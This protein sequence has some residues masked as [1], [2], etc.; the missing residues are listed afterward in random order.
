M[1]VPAFAKYSQDRTGGG[2][3]Y[4]AAKHTELH[5]EP[6]SGEG[7]WVF[8][9]L[10]WGD[11]LSLIIKGWIG[12]YEGCGVTAVRYAREHGYDTVELLP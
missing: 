4:S 1:N 8:E 9:L 2:V 11:P 5:G 10:N 7:T 12:D 3:N 6:P